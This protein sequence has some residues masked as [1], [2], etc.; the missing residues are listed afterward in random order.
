M[1]VGVLEREDEAYGEAIVGKTVDP[2][3]AVHAGGDGPAKRV[4]DVARL[5][6]IGLHVPEFL[7]ADAIGLRIDVVEF[8]CGD[9][10]FGE[11]AAW[12]FG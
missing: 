12:A 3:A 1:G 11:R 2:S 9:E 7:D 5:N 10:I 6:A 8:F 4:G